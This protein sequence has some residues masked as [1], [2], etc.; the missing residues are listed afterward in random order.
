MSNFSTEKI[1]FFGTIFIWTYVT[2]TVFR[3]K[4]PIAKRIPHNVYYGVNPVKKEEDRGDNP[5]NPPIF[6]TDYYYW[7]RDDARSNPEV[8]EYLNSENAYCKQEMKRLSSLQSDLYNEILSHLQETDSDVPYK[9]GDYLYYSRTQAGLPYKI[10]C[11]KSI[12]S[13]KEKII[14]DENEVLDCNKIS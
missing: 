11:R 4:P 13:E 14:L 1:C 7:L 3:L 10:H 6:K 8:L 12:F 5:M 2:G 9:E